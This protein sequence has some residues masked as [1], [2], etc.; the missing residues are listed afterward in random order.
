[1][2]WFNYLLKVSAC[3]VFFFVF[4]LLV[5]RRLTFFKINRFYLLFTL[6]LSFVIPTLHFT[7]E[8]E[9][10]AASAIDMPVVTQEESTIEQIAFAPI[11]TTAPSMPM[12]ESFDWLNLLP[13]LYISVVCNLLA[14]A[15]WRLFKLIKHAKQSTQKINGLKLVPKSE[16]FTNCSF[17]N[18]VF[19]DENNLTENELQVLLRHE[20][21]HVKNYHSVDKILLIIAK[22]VL[23]FNPIIYLYDKALEQ[24]K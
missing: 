17:F 10:E 18:Y 4:Y 12:E 19:I 24:M 3:S 7:I 9:V 11:I 20:E 2:E 5:L 23:W 22:A 15:S 14:L 13:Y 21:V 8:R 6:L 1:M 16:G